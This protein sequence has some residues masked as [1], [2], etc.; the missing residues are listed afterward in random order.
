LLGGI[1]SGP[2]SCLILAAD[3]GARPAPA[4]RPGRIVMPWF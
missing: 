4:N 3:A 1:V 2:L